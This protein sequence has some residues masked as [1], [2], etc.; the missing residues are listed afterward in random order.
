MISLILAALAGIFNAFMDELHV[1]SS[2]RWNTLP[3]T[4][5]FYKWAGGSWKN[6]WKCYP[7]GSVIQNT[8]RLW[9]YLWLYKP[10]LKERFAYSSTLLVFT[11]DAWHFFQMCWRVAIT[12]A[13]VFYS[14]VITLEA[15][16][17]WITSFIYLSV[18]Y[19]IPFNIFYEYILRKR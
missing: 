10:P 3:K 4:N 11:T 7:N 8:K 14:P 1:W 5:W 6:K 15:I 18:A 19:L 2:S 9:Y 12:L 13:V 17:I 16:P